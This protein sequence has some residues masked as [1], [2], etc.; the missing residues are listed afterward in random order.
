MHIHLAICVCD[1]LNHLKQAKLQFVGPFPTCHQSYTVHAWYFLTYCRC[2]TLFTSMSS[3]L[4][5]YFLAQIVHGMLSPSQYSLKKIWNE[6]LWLQQYLLSLKVIYIEKSWHSS[7]FLLNLFLVKIF[8]PTKILRI[9]LS[10][11]KLNN[12]NEKYHVL[13][14]KILMIFFIFIHI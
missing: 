9:C 11:M 10:L 13:F 4:M 7:S 14:M 12:E 6:F 2:L 5:W 1:I 3:G 8:F